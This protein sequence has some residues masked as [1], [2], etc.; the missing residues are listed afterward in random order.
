MDLVERIIDLMD[1]RNITAAQLTREVPLTNGVVTQ[2]KQ[3]KQKPSLDAVV[4]LAK[5][6]DVTTDSLL[7]GEKPQSHLRLVEGK[8]E[9]K[10]MINEKARDALKQLDDLFH[11]SLLVLVEAESEFITNDEEFQKREIEKESDLHIKQWA[12]ELLALGLKRRILELW[13]RYDFE[14]IPPN[15]EVLQKMV[16][17][18]GK[19]TG[20]DEFNSSAYHE[21]RKLSRHVNDYSYYVE[22]EAKETSSKNS[23]PKIKEA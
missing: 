6:F 16:D 19:Y 11:K 23:E 7:M 18:H 13:V 3:G 12:E 9:D 21:I 2:W 20:G 15:N 10:I 17:I 5:Y 8:K 22:V 4:K 1:Q 14:L